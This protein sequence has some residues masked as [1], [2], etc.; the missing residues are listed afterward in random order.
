MKNFRWQILIAVIALVAVGLVLLSQSQVGETITQIIEPAAQQGGVYVEGLIGEPIRFNPLL[1]DYNQVDQDVTRLVFSRLIRFDSWGNPQPE[2][3]ESFGV[4]VIGD[5]YNVQMR[6]NALW[7]DGTPVTTADVLFTISL[8][9]DGEMPVPADVRA[10]W[11]SV[12]VTAFDALNLQFKLAEPYAPFMDYLSFGILPKHIL[13]DKSPQELINDPFNLLPVGSGPYQVTD[14]RS[15]NGKITAVVL[16]AFPD[17]YMGEPLIE[18][19]VLRYFESSAD[20]L[21]AYQ[22]GEILGIG[23]VDPADLEAV[24]AEP[25][26]N[27]FSVRVPE[28]VMVLFN[29]GDDSPAFFKDTVFRQAMMTALNRSWMIDQAMEGQAIL[30]NSPIMMGSWAYFGDTETYDFNPEEAVK[31]LRAGGYGLPADGSL[32]R[33]KDGVRLSFDMIYTDKPEYK[34][35]AEMIRDYWADV[36]VGVNIIPIPADAIYRD[37]LGPRNYQ[38]ALVDLALYNSPDP[39]PYPFWHQ[40]MATSGQ[41]YSQWNDRR[42]SEYLERARVTPDR[43][44]RARMYRNF[45]IHFSRELPALPLFTKI[46]NYP[47]DQQVQGVQLGPLYDPADRFD[48]VYLWSLETR[49]IVEEAPQVE[50]GAE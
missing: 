18:Q 42:A 40:A 45:Q 7:H 44:E 43:L 47:I 39:D 10:L 14:L 1:D 46:Y 15:E 34:V 24:L 27:I 38:A 48:Q 2:L 32:I 21:E 3:A 28:M 6:E 33:E 8:M 5:I 30:A 35:V 4:S 26:L 16:E 19:I 23:S 41:N 25:N 13:Q 9:R 50:Q 29:L 20:A 12:Q 11:N 49:P 17:Y 37:Y 22:A 36:G 31:M